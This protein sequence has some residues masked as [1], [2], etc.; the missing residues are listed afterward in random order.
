MAVFSPLR[1]VLSILVLGSVLFV[2]GRAQAQSI[3]TI[4]DTIAVDPDVEVEL[5]AFRG[6]VEVTS[7]DR[8]A[9]RLSGQ[10]EDTTSTPDE[11]PEIQVTR[12]DSTLTVKPNG[13]TMDLDI[14]TVLGEIT[15]LGGTPEGPTTRYSV[16]V[17]A[18]A[19]VTLYLD[20][21]DAEVSGVKGDVRVVG[22]TS[23]VE[24]RNVEGEVDAGTL[25]GPL[26]AEDIR[27]ELIMGTAHGDLQAN[28]STVPQILHVDS[29]TGNAEITLPADAAFD[30][31]T[32]ITWGSGVTSDFA[33]PDSSSQEDG[34]IPIGGGGPTVFFESFS[35]RLTLKAE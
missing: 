22:V 3:H 7:W 25:S 4:T 13:K 33:M 24:I 29:Y 5:H 8:A 32:D 18:D 30:L 23:S 26:Y 17:P 9:V 14:F 2:G 11:T 10:I 28:L 35:G 27:G 31:K 6:R 1:R 15:W 16:R 19:S 20:A 21:A 34:T 12:R